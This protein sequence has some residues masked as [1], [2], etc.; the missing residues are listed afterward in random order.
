MACLGKLGEEVDTMRVGLFV[1]G[2]TEALDL[3]DLGSALTGAVQGE[4]GDR[5]NTLI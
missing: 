1:V 5:M 4:E 2:K 3:F